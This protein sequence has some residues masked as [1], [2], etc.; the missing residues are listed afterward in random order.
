MAFPMWNEFAGWVSILLG[1][2]L[3][4][5]M[6]V[7]FQSESWLGGYAA[8]RRRM[9]RLAHVAFIALGMTN[10]IAVSSLSRSSLRAPLPGVASWLLIASALLMPSCCLLFAA[11]FRRYEVFAV[12]VVSLAIGL[13]LIIGGLM[14]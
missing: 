2:V 10:V 3:G 8:L 12:P 1:I 11:G 6:G 4:M 9:F 13:L 5:Y 7:K 14:P